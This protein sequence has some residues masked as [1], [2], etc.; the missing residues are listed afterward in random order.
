MT[1]PLQ[2]A[3][4]GA[5]VCD[6]EATALARELG[7]EIARAGAVL[8]CGGRS[9]VMAAACA[10]A[11]AEGGTTVGVLPGVD[12]ASSPPN[13]ALDI[14][15][16][17]GMHQARNQL[18]VLSGAAVIAVGGGWGTLSEIACAL[19]YRVPVVLLESWNLKRPD[20]LNDPLLISARTAADA[21]QLALQASKTGRPVTV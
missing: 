7:A 6:D 4:V 5:A 12:E 16:Y 9:G 19:K 21:V 8:V 17:S 2:I 13:D 14:V 10:G 3:V 11:K 1:R 15:L 18:L 20:G